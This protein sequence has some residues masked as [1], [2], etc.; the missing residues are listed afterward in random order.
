MDYR[1]D[2]IDVE[3]K[4]GLLLRT[5][6]WKP[7][8]KTDTIVIL[9]SGICSN[10]FQN[11]LLE[12]TGDTLAKNGYAYI[13]GQ[14]MDAYTLFNYSNLKTNKQEQKGVLFDD[15][16]VVYED[17][18]AYVNYA[19]ELGYKNIILAGHSLGS[20]KIIHY[21]SINHDFA[22]KFFIVSGAVDLAKFQDVPLKETYIK[23]AKQ[24]VRENRGDE[25]LPFLIVGFSPMSANTVLEFYNNKSLKNCPVFSHDGDFTAL[26][27]ISVKGTFIVG[28]K[29][30]CA[31]EN[32]Y[33]FIKELNS[34]T[35]CSEQ[36]KLIVLEN[37]GHIF[38]GK[39]NEYADTILNLV[40]NM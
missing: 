14:A 9:M 37:S 25:I 7:E 24:F 3:T 8:H 17:I 28:D 2:F 39:H 15:F 35:Q 31:G 26:S 22:I 11:K 36:N 33:E 20:N 38:H 23:M 4:R 10:I 40:K 32:P 1:I 18:D 30:S 13:C 34:H 21:L 19:K 5:L 12:T 6:M 29:D 16:D 27:K